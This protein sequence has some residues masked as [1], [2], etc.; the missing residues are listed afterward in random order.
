MRLALLL[1]ALLVVVGTALPLIREPYWWIRVFD[2]PRVQI[3]VLGLAVLAAYA[4]HMRRERGRYRRSYD[5]AVIALLIA[6]LG[7]QAW[8]IWPYTPLHPVQSAQAAAPD[9]TR[10]FRLVISNVLMDNRYAQR[11]LRE[12]RAAEPDLVVMLEPDA[13]WVAQAQSLR[14][15][16]PHAVERPLDN[17]YGI[18][19]YSRFPLRDA[20]VREVVEDSIPSIWGAFDLPSGDRIRFA[21]IHPRPPQPADDTDERDAELILVA[22]EVEDYDGPLV[23]AGDFND[24][25][26]SYTTELFQEISGLLDPRVGRGLYSTFHAAYPP[27]RWPLD[28]AFHSDDLALVEMRRL[29]NTKSDHFPLLAVFAIAPEAEAVQDA[30]DA[31]PED[32][33]D[34]DAILDE[35]RD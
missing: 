26:W 31:G 10:T 27:L 3:A 6:A 29:G 2:F 5:A 13:W 35:A 19:L 23:V 30:P 7:Y 16:L 22:R 24:V 17:T 12:V 21:F 4:W 9:A 14:R 25:A 33:E 28:H 20:E 8:C 34:A 1:L 18:A 32:H 11:W 15:E